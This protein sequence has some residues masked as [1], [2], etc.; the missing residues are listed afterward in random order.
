MK[1]KFKLIYIFLLS[2]FFAQCSKEYQLPEDLVVHDF[3]WKGLNAYYL[4]Q[5]EIA[6]LSDRRFSSD[7]ELNAYLRTFKDYNDLFNNLLIPTDAKSNL[8]ED[9][10]NLNVDLPRSSFT[11]GL[12]FGII[13]EPGSTEN[14]IGYVLQILP[15]S[16]A[17]TKNISRGEF[18]NAVDGVQLTRDNFVDL[19]INGT[20][21]FDLSMVNFDG[22]NVI[23]N[24]KTISLEKENYD[25]DSV[26]L[27]KTFNIGTFNIGYVMYNN[28]FSKAAI[29]NLNTTFLNLKNNAVNKLVLDLRYNIGGGS[30]ARNI[31]NLATMITGQFTDEVFIKEEWNSKAQPW[32]EANQPDSLLTKFPTKLNPQTDFN[33]LN[34]TDVYII[35]NGNNFTGSSAIEL[36]INSLQPYINVHIIGT[37]TAGN[38]TGSI[39]LFNSEDY[40]FALRNETHTV[41]LQP[42]VLSF[43][44]I[45]DQTY[46]NGFAP[47]I[48]ICPNEDLLDLG[49][50]GERSEPILDSVLDFVT[51]GNTGA[52]TVCNPNNYEFLFHSIDMQRERDNGMFIEQDLPNTN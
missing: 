24:T 32:F 23:P 1:N 15:N 45:N 41:A 5:D 34:L 8:V 35:L 51:S 2:L 14:V 29:N 36:L 39:T 10:T 27:E 44:N 33:S 30:F 43:Y 25:Y 31:T 3:V 13:A 37:N 11:N 19:L 4:H 28:D 17:S 26:F 12:E 52:N 21:N 49:I 18:F 42:I 46:E 22:T 9:Y 50:L 7:Q 38:N 16:N 6:D 47:T 40:D 48:S 20:S